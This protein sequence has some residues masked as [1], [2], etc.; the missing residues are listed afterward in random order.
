MSLGLRTYR[1]NTQRR[2]YSQ[3][4]AAAA[5][6]FPTSRLSNLILSDKGGLAGR[7]PGDMACFATPSFQ[8]RSV[9]RWRLPQKA[10][11]SHHP[12]DLR[13]ADEG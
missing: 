13:L 9:E 4:E 2:L 5:L 1:T 7:S 6:S 11:A 8:S 10:T 3:T 12:S